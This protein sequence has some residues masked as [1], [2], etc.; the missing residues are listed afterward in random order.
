MKKLIPAILA[1][2]CC[3]T[4]A[5]AG[6]R[7]NPNLAAAHSDIEDALRN[8]AAAH[9]GPAQFGGHRARAEEFLQAALREVREAAEFADERPLR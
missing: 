5:V 6:L 8:L 9:N 7:E 4:I 3:A 1:L 2:S